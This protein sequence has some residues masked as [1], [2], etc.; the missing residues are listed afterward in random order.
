[1]AHWVLRGVLAIATRPGYR[2]GDERAVERHEVEQW[3]ERVRAQGI[4]SILCLLG[5][6]QLP[7]YDKALPQGLLA[8]Y[9]EAGFTVAHLPAHD[10][11]S[12]PF[13]PEEYERAWRLFLE[14]PRPLL[15]HC[16]AGH[17]RTGRIVRYILDRLEGEAE[18]HLL[19]ES[20]AS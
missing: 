6:D 3:V 18:R 15:V 2:P 5:D 13:S 16:S 7:L 20:A 17:D 11:L 12:E 8:F 1:V 19:G 4:R 14:L 10:G 9:E